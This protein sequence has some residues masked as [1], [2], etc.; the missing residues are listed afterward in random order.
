LKTGGYAGNILLIDLTTEKIKKEPLKREFASNYIGGWGMNARL[1]YDLIKPGM[2][3]YDPEIP[4]IFGAGLLT[5]TL[6]PG[7]P[8]S[9]FTTKDAASGTVVTAVG[10]LAFG[11]RLK[12]AGYDHVIITGIRDRPGYLKIVDEDIELCDATDLW[13]CDIVETTKKL[14]ERYGE[15]SSVACIGPAGENQV[16]ISILLNDYCSTLG[17]SFAANLGFRK[18]KA[19]VIDGTKGIRVADRKRFMRTVDE[20][21]VRAM[22]DPLREKWT[23]Q[24][25]YSLFS[26]WASAGYFI[27][28]NASEVYPESNAFETFGPQHFDKVRK[29]VIGCP[30]CITPDKF[31]LRFGD[32]EFQGLEMMLSTPMVP[33]ISFGIRDEVG[34]FD[35]ACW[36]F[37]QANRLGLDAMTLSSLIGFAMDLYQRGVITKSD[38]DGLELKPNFETTKKLLEMT[39]AKEGFGAILA[40]GFGGV[41]KRFGHGEEAYQ[42]KGT[43][44]DFDARVSFGVEAFGS[45]VN[46]RGAHDMP[47]GGLTVAKG[48]KPDFFQK[49]VSKIGYVHEDAM[50]RIFKENGFDLG[51]LTAHYEN[52]ATL[53]NCLGICFRM[54]NSILYD[55]RIAAE[56]YSAATGIEKNPQ[57]LLR[58]AERAYNLYK[59]LN[60]REGF[61]RKDDRFPDQWFAPLRRPDKGEDLVLTDYF[62]KKSLT[63]GE[64]ERMLDAYYEEKGWDKEKGIPTREKLIE[65]GIEE[66]LEGVTS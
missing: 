13:G 4:L 28:K 62:G 7:S 36:M 33:A 30:S 17:R 18:L 61:N 53:L 35:R 20:M 56:L 52:W 51:R 11:T 38:T 32:G 41:I 66:E 39:T 31:L 46:P 43:E 26:L 42:I 9:F 6:S 1:A 49:V 15:S 19:I 37:Y 22:E 54:Q 48:R 21:T 40:E 5:G 27:Y 57:E 58:D 45:I 3:V 8:K 50:E 25:V 23:H 2:D 59:M 64:V 29:R 47:V 14:K 65:L 60:V 63:R 55:S 10:S 34:N 12:W 24:G 16:K 44:P